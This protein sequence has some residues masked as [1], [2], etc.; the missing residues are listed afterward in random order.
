MTGCMKW[1]VIKNEEDHYVAIGDHNHVYDDSIV[2]N[3]TE[4]ELLKDVPQ[5]TAMATYMTSTV[6]GW[7]VV[8]SFPEITNIVKLIPY[9]K[10]ME[11]LESGLQDYYIYAGE[12]IQKVQGKNEYLVYDNGY[13]M[14]WFLGTT[15]EQ[16]KAVMNIVR[17]NCDEIMFPE[18]LYS[19]LIDSCDENF[20][21]GENAYIMSSEDMSQV[22][23]ITLNGFLIPEI[24]GYDNI[25]MPLNVGF[26]YTI[27]IPK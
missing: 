6:Y 26:R 12:E 24:F 15:R 18:F 23:P 13:G 10:D 20:V 7:N 2:S 27:E 1:Y 17:E 9:L 4:D 21:C 19:D 25:N 5:T 22:V 11:D 3:A 14:I 16:L 8:T